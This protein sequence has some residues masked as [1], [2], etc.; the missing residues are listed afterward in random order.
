MTIYSGNYLTDYSGIRGFGPFH[1]KET[2]LESHPT[3]RQLILWMDLEMTGLDPE[4]DSILEIAA[5]V[6][7]SDLELVEEGPEFV[8]QHVPNEF[9][10]MDRWNQKQHIKSGLWARALESSITTDEA[11][12]RIL[13]FVKQFF[14]KKER[15]LIAG[16]SIW[17]DRRFII[18]HMP[19]LEE[20][21]HYRMIDVSSLKIL[22][23]NWYPKV[24]VPKKKE[25][26]RAMDDIKESIEELKFYK[27]YIFRA[28]DEVKL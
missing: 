15:A 2:I 24:T 4:K 17:Q 23:K 19:R 16:N 12:K 6:T 3:N 14:S 25:N 21:L 28:H 10:L 27:S 20:Y 18:N 1:F 9:D 11:E 7:D 8:I 22:T 26:H 13:K 5:I